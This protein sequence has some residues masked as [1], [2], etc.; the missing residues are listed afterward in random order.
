MKWK[1]N[2]IYQKENIEKLLIIKISF[3]YKKEGG[4]YI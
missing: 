4:D 1:E 2:N 3:K